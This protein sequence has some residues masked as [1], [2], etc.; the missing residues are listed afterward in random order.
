M[1]QQLQPDTDAVT[2]FPFQQA[3]FPWK[4]LAY[5]MYSRDIRKHTDNI[6]Y[7][8]SDPEYMSSYL[9]YMQMHSVLAQALNQQE[10]VNWVAVLA[11]KIKG[12][13]FF[14]MFNF[15]LRISHRGR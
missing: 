11:L 8:R 10:M 1:I 3:Q 6:F 12:E 7:L 5:Y 13:A 2:F 14:V 9:E 4:Y 15:H